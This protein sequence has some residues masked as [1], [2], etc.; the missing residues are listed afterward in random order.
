MSNSKQKS[1]GKS[2]STRATLTSQPLRS[3]DDY[4][5]Q[6]A[7]MY[8]EEGKNQHA[9]ASGLGVSRA[10]VVNYLQQAR[11]RR[12]VRIQLDNDLF[13]GHELSKQLCSHY[14][15]NS[16]YVLPDMPDEEEETVFLRVAK[17]AAIWLSSLL[18]PDDKLGVSWGRTV[19]ELAEAMEIN[20][21]PGVSVS[22]L[23]GSMST[24]YG[25]TAEICST[26][27]AHKLSASCINLHAPAILSDAALAHRLRQEPIIKA[28]LDALTSCNKAVFAAGTCE[29]DSHIVGSGVATVQELE[30]YKKQGAVG[31]ICG[32]LIDRDGQEV[33]GPLKERM[34]AVSLDDLRGLDIGL[35]VSTGSDRITPMLAALKG[36]YVT[37][38]ATSSTTAKALIDHAV[39][40]V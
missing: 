38:L 34:M 26:T 16:A 5:I 35:L 11:E 30:W 13:S 1:G 12:Y 31:V 10:S 27:L 8:Y 6:A 29:S 33:E 20:S 9:I 22:Q 25:F 28:Q 36:G 7:W 24:P 19:Y 21:I 17:G 18:Q 37:H 39:S 23:V 4:I 2:T 40:A 15:L 3:A 14:G 32:R